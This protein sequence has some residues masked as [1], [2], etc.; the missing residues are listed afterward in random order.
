[1]IGHSIL[2]KIIGADFFLAPT[3]TDL[4]FTRSGIFRLFFTLF[5]FEQTCAHDRERFLLV[6][7]LTAS[8]LTP[9]DPSSWDMQNLHRRIGCVHALSTRSA[10]PRNFNS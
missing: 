4:T 9:H 10:R 2:R 3:G 8:V 7:L 5:V 6:L 1:M